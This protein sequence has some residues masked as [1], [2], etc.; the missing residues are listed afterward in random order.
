MTCVFLAKN[1]LGL[2][3]L[4]YGPLGPVR[5]SQI[6]CIRPIANSRGYHVVTDPKGLD[7]VCRNTKS[8][9]TKVETT[10]STPLESQVAWQLPR[11]FYR[12]DSRVVTLTS[13]SPVMGRAGSNGE[14]TYGVRT[15]I[16]PRFVKA[17]GA[18]AM[19]AKRSRDTAKEYIRDAR[20]VS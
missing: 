12:S 5:L 13:P 10:E 11:E 1:F 4:T 2:I 20:G 17:D 18:G 14:N 15:G 7:R 3:T 9:A 6:R 16:S 19:R 8:T